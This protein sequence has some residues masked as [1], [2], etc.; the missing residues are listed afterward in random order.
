MQRKTLDLPQGRISYLER[1]KAD[2]GQPCL[3]F[4]HGLMGTAATFAPCL[5]ALPPGRHAI[6]IDLPGAGFSERSLA[7][8]PALH[9]MSNIVRRVLDALELERPLLVGYS[10]GGAVALHMA[11]SEPGRVRGL[12]LLAPAHPYF[13][14]ADKIIAFYL[15]PPGRAFAHTVPW[16]PAW[17]QRAGLR[18]IAGPHSWDP[19]ERLTPY[20][21][22]LR[23]PGTIAFLLRL[24]RTWHT[25]MRGL[26]FLLQAP[27]SLPALVIWGD[28]DWVVPVSTAPDLLRRLRNGELEVLP[29]VGHRPAEERPEVCA[30]LIEGW[31]KRQATTSPGPVSGAKES[32]R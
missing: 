28:H 15:S 25:D 11:A 31:W 3:V 5:E 19:P 16:Y 24:L 9:S 12:V 27:F 4:L 32:F 14:Q 20:R 17:M 21:E 10:H 22:N 30:E 7:V 13:R 29:G 6:A 18:R 26:Q 23:T 1:G 2:A 8:S